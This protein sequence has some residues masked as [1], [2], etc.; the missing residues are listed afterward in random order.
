MAN[1]WREYRDK[2]R[3]FPYD[4]VLQQR[5]EAGEVDLTLEDLIMEVD[6]REMAEMLRKKGMTWEEYQESDEYR[7]VLEEGMRRFWFWG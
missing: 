7:E 2:V 6:Q 1:A 4:E 3:N 5:R